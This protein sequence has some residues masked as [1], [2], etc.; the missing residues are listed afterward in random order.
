MGGNDSVCLVCILEFL[1][2]VFLKYIYNSNKNINTNDYTN[3]NSDASYLD[4]KINN[5]PF[6]KNGRSSY[7]DIVVETCSILF[8]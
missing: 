6:Q 8:C 2:G 1:F 3:S 5:V 7:N 4:M